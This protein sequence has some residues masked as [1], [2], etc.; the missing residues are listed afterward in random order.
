MGRLVEAELGFELLDEL[1]IESLCPAIAGGGFCPPEKSPPPPEMREVA[2]ES[3]PCSCAMMRSTGP[4]GANC[5]ITKE[6]SMI[7]RSVGIMRR[8]RRA[9]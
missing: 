2:P 1:G 3:C 9:I 5:T 4:P 8:T 7:P 6:I